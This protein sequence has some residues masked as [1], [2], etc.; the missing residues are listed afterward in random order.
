MKLKLKIPTKLTP[1]QKELMEEFKV[2]EIGSVVSSTD[3]KDPHKDSSSFTIQQ[4]WNRLKEFLKQ[5][6]NESEKKTDQ[7]QKQ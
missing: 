3:S 7:Q 2:E 6:P 5:P 1:R 4:A